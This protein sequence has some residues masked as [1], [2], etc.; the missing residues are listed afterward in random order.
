[1]SPL[2]KAI[3]SVSRSGESATPPVPKLETSEPG[4]D[5]AMDCFKCHGEGCSVCGRTGWI[6]IA[7]AGMV[8]P[9]VLEGV[10]NDPQVYTGFAVGF[11][12]ERIAMLK[13]GIEDIR[14][15]YANDPRFLRQ[16]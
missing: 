3:P 6:E 14:L 1:M 2:W 9:R 8:H 10:G 15:F 4:V 13:H 5:V 11:G 12:V 16:F 7:G